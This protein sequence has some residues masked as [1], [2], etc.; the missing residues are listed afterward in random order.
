MTYRP[1]T[2]DQLFAIAVNAG[3]AELASHGRFAAAEPDTV[4]ALAEGIG[5]LAA[6]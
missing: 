6:G 5:A 2:Q 3:I 1:A 4:E